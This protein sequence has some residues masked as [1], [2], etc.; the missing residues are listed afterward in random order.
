MPCIKAM[1]LIITKQNAKSAS[2]VTMGITPSIREGENNRRP[3]WS[4]LVNFTIFDR[5]RQP[6]QSFGSAGVV[7]FYMPKYI[8]I[9]CLA[10]RRQP[11]S[12]RRARGTISLRYSLRYSPMARR[13]APSISS[14]L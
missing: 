7:S 9:Y 4:H 5:K 10:L 8:A 1:T 12:H 2:Y 3:C 11:K 6:P 14:A 13:T